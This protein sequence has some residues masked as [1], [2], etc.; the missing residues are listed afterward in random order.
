[1]SYVVVSVFLQRFE[2]CTSIGPS[3]V[4]SQLSKSVYKILRNDYKELSNVNIYIYKN[5]CSS[6]ARHSRKLHT[7]ITH[8]TN[9]EDWKVLK[10]SQ[11]NLRSKHN[12]IILFNFTTDDDL[13]EVETFG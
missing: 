7:F 4:I 13:I 6:V 5:V 2:G 9:F 3:V 10:S 8:N 12:N 1:M 11:T